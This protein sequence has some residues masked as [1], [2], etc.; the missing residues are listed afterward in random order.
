MLVEGPLSNLQPSMIQFSKPRRSMMKS[1][2]YRRHET[3]AREYLAPSGMPVD[4][5]CYNHTIV[6]A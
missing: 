5:M 3:S 2:E 4:R 1:M 6:R